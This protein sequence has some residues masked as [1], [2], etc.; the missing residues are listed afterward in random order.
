MRI[1][2]RRLLI[3]DG[4]INALLGFLLLLFPLGVA[5]ALGVPAPASYLYTSLLG[6]VLLGIGAALLIES[7]HG[8]DGIRG[9]GLAGAIAINFS[10]ACVLAIWLMATSV[11]IPVRGRVLLWTIAVVV[12]AI[13][14]VELFSKSWKQR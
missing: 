14:L 10:G 12:M 4:G 8:S 5:P 6:A 13:G 11:D 9:L 2:S 7:W 3:V 1:S